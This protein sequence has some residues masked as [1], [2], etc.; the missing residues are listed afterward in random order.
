MSARVVRTAFGA[1][2][3]LQCAGPGRQHFCIRSPLEHSD[4]AW[5]TIGLRH[6]ARANLTG[7]QIRSVLAF[8]QVTNTNPGQPIP[9]IRAETIDIPPV[10]ATAPVSDDRSVI[11]RGDTLV[12]YNACIGCHVV[13]GSGGGLGP[14]LTDVVRRR[15]AVAVHRK[16]ANPL[17]DNPTSMMPNFGFTTE[18]I[19][20]ITAYLAALGRR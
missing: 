3:H 11:A 1:G 13:G 2:H 14:S 17:F 8:L 6:R 18:Q 10:E 9:D 5:V 16:L 15:G 20:A 19:D 12:H 7:S 4:R